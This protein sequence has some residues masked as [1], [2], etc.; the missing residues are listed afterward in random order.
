MKKYAFAA[1]FLLLSSTVN[2]GSSISEDT[3]IP[4]KLEY[5]Q[6]E[7][8]ESIRQQFVDLYTL[9]IK[10]EEERIR[11]WQLNKRIISKFTQPERDKISTICISLNIKDEH[12]YKIMKAESGFNPKAVNKLSYATGLIGFL[13][14][15][16]ERLGMVSTKGIEFEGNTKAER[17]LNKKKYISSIIQEMTVSQQLDY[18]NKYFESICK[19]H[20]LTTYENVWLAVFHPAA[21]S[22]SN[23]HIAGKKNSKM[24]Q[25][26]PTFDINK[27]GIITVSE[28]KQKIN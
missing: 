8:H 2:S 17:E 28:L 18:V 14:S 10:Q 16:A 25:Q 9:S 11:L 26:N 15:T 3:R 12:L 23:D 5:T 27:D 1:L 20:K 4:L 13:P 6:E 19:R 24:V 21:I 7:L 22:K